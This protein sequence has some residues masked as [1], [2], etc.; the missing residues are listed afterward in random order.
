M[1]TAEFSCSAFYFS[2]IPSETEKARIKCTK[3]YKLNNNFYIS[4]LIMVG[5]TIFK[6][7]GYVY[8]T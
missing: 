3:L 4:G 7:S 6:Y 2:A 8:L 5:Y 1:I